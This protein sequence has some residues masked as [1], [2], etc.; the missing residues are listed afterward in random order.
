MLAGGGGVNQN[1]LYKSF[2]GGVLCHIVPWI[3][4]RS[5]LVGVGR[6]LAPEAARRFVVMMSKFQFLLISK[7]HPDMATAGAI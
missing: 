3:L 7:L 1:P 4:K 2:S 6:Q 5:A